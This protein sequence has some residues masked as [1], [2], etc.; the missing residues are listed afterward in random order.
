MKYGLMLVGSIIL[1]II[2]MGCSGSNSTPEKA[3]KLPTV[4]PGTA[5]NDVVEFS[6]L[7]K[8]PV[9]KNSV[10]PEYP[11]SLQ[12]SG[13]DGR[14]ILQ[15]IVEKDGTVSN[16]RVLKSS[17]HEAMDNAAIEAFQQFLF[18][19]GEVN[20]EPVRTKVVVPFQ[21]RVKKE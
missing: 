9:V 14:V 15:G 13:T 3:P 4:Q 8:K 18:E 7:D 11:E 10:A 17:G 19:P 16:I 20:G 21:F 5:S 2:T 6:A 12:Q 1:G